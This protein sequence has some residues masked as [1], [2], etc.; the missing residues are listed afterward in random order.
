MRIPNKRW[1][2]SFIILILTFLSTFNL[3][4]QPK[5]TSEYSTDTLNVESIFFKKDR[6]VN[7]SFSNVTYSEI[8]RA[9]GAAEDV[10]KYFQS[11]AGVSTGYDLYND[12]IVRGG[13]PSENLTLV[14]GMEIPNPN[15]FGIPGTNSGL[16]S[17]INL[18]L[19]NDVN[20][21]TGGF[22]AKY[23]DRI[24]SVMDIKFREGSKIKHSQELS[25]SIAGFGGFFEGP[26]SKNSS[27]MFSVRR[28]YFELLKDQLRGNP[29]PNYWD[30]NLKLNYDAGK[31][32]KI[33]LIGFYVI[34]KASREFSVGELQLAKIYIFSG[35]V[36]YEKLF[37]KNIF[38]VST[39]VNTSNTLASYD[40][41]SLSFPTYDIDVIENE[42]GIKSE[43]KYRISGSN[44]LEF[45]VSGKYIYSNDKIYANSFVT[46]T[47][48]FRPFLDTTKNIRTSKFNA[49]INSNNYLFNKKLLINA[50]ARA[51]IFNY[52]DEKVTVAPR[53]G[54]SYRLFPNTTLNASA[55]IF[56]QTPSL[57][58]LAASDANKNLKSIRAAQFVLGIEHF[59]RQDILFKMEAYTKEYSNYP[60]SIYDPYSIYINYGTFFG[61]SFLDRATSIGEGTYKGLDISLIKKL[62]RTGLYG[63]L[64]ISFSNSK[65]R[66][67]KNVTFPLDFDYGK[68]LTLVAG[69]QLK[70]DW[71]FGIRM[72]FSDGRPYTPFDTYISE[73]A[74]R[75][76]YDMTKFYSARMPAYSR[77][78]ARID[79]KF[80]FNAFNLVLYVEVQNLMNKDNVYEYYWNR[81][82]NSVDVNYDWEILPVIGISAK[83]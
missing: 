45:S 12:L 80:R 17:Y 36:E 59:F 71:L 10:I 70:D 57:I 39:F 81:N 28:S 27:Y 77:I 21:Y 34:D 60:V 40:N 32:Q 3:F 61:T 79:K 4:A 25:L 33:K 35:L 76:L 23:G 22:P 38:S 58:I 83:F 16:L 47:G 66:A 19:V 49:S 44:N 73:S 1:G 8:R 55:G 68:Q 15:H 67:A 30:F 78:D 41:K 29:I 20:F 72:K 9:P 75:G 52:L 2:T 13:A 14:D 63:S 62:N 6:D 82:S 43:Y 48:Y 37:G 24:S 74:N 64:A 69:Y 7:V 50:G 65:F 51:D 11:T 31:D 56:F 46:P 26:I 54:L 18:R 5:D 53:L 42:A